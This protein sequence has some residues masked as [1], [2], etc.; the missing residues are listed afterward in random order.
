MFTDCTSLE[1]ITIP[2]SVQSINNSFIRCTSLKSIV[3]TGLTGKCLLGRQLTS[4]ETFEVNE[5]CT[6]M[7]A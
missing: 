2:A 7:G 1:N 6:E 4:L 3:A 5:G